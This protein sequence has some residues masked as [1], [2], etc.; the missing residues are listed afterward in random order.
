MSVLK[1]NAT[2]IE[3]GTRK[4]KKYVTVKMLSMHGFD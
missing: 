4:K 2:A 1:I 3:V